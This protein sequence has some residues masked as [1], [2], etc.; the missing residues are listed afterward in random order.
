MTNLLQPTGRGCGF[1]AQAGYVWSN[2][3]FPFSASALLHCDMSDSG[4]FVA[5]LSLP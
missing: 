1:F 2:I 3:A 5:A 4:S